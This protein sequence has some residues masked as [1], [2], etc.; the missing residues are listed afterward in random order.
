VVNIKKESG[1][2]SPLNYIRQL[3]DYFHFFCSGRCGSGRYGFVPYDFGCFAY[4]GCCGFGRF[5]FDCYF[6][7]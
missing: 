2:H 3:I 7:Y 1:L 4:F 6:C 5:Y